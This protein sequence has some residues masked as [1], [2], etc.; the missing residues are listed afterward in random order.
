M[1]EEKLLTLRELR[2][3]LVGPG[4]PFHTPPAPATIRGWL[5]QGLK[6]HVLP[7]GARKR[8]R[9]SEVL[10]FLREHTEVVG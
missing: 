9:L 8:Y 10:A 4:C 3:A 2:I 7:G 5:E 1:S 6:H